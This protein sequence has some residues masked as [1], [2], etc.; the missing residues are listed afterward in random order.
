MHEGYTNR[1][2]QKDTKKV[3][4]GRKC[5]LATFKRRNPQDYSDDSDIRK[6]NNQDRGNDSN[7][8][9][10]IFNQD[11][12]HVCTGQTQRRFKVTEN[13]MGMIGPTEG[14]RGNP[15]NLWGKHKKVKESCRE[16]R[17]QLGVIMV[18]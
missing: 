6:G 1:E 16:L 13:L 17:T 18:G 4:T 9:D 7:R 12:G 15:C 14:H 10:H 5:L 8:M 11:H 2:Y 3:C